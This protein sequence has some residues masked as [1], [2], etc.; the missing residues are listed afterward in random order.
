MALGAA[1][2]AAVAGCGK[3]QP[4]ITKAQYVARANAVCADVSRTVKA[5]AVR[6][7]PITVLAPRVLAVRQKAN[8]RLR[9][10]PLPADSSVP[11]EW[12]HLREVA[13]ADAKQIFR[14]TPHSPAYRAATLRYRRA[15]TQVS[16][17][18]TRYG[19]GECVGVASN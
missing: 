8:A 4:Q 1:A 5:L 10:I 16:G 2:A 6:Q 15:E 18:A 17:V 11:T 13:L 3:S 7:V 12:L 19:L 14:A 9:S